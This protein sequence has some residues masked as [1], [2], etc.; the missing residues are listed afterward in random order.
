[1]SSI[2]KVDEIQNTGGTTGLTIN[3]SGFVLPKVPVVKY[4]QRQDNTFLH[5]T[6]LLLRQ[7]FH[8]V[9]YI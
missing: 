9:K 2:L 8:Q 6:Q 7:S 5:L 4:L 3:S 1:M